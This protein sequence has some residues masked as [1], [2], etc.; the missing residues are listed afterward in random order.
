MTRNSSLKSEGSL[1]TNAAAKEQVWAKAATSTGSAKAS[2]LCNSYFDIS[3]IGSLGAQLLD[4]PLAVARAMA[5]NPFL[6][7]SARVYRLDSLEAVDLSVCCDEVTVDNR[8]V[9]S[10]RDRVSRD[11]PTFSLIQLP[12]DQTYPD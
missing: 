3:A 9:V 5:R 11:S 6:S 7:F 12:F 2:V 4:A 8:K 10:K 1:S